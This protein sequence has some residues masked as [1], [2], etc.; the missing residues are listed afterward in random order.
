[1]G[2]G[3][4]TQAEVGATRTMSADQCRSEAR[5][6]KNCMWCVSAGRPL[7]NGGPCLHKL[8]RAPTYVNLD[9]NWS[10]RRIHVEGEDIRG[11]THPAQGQQAIPRVVKSRSTMMYSRPDSG[12]PSASPAQRNRFVR[13]RLCSC[14]SAPCLPSGAHRRMHGRTH[15]PHA[16][17]RAAS[18]ATK[19]E[20]QRTHPP[21][22]PYMWV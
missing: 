6:S 8:C 1:M 9:N 15:V 19:S 17:Q 4:R 3:Y 2:S 22:M 10:R 14:V 16:C 20:Q 13:G 7:C 12:Y 11:T 21:D 5:K 18:L